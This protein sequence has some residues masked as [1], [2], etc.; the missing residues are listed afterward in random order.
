MHLSSFSTDDA[1]DA[2]IG[3]S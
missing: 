2:A 1:T 3:P